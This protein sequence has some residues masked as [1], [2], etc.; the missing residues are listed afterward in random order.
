MRP[1][2]ISG[3]GV[4]ALGDEE[5]GTEEQTK[6]RSIKDNGRLT[7]LGERPTG[8]SRSESSRQKPQNDRTTETEGENGLLETPAKS[9][10]LARHMT[11]HADG[12][13]ARGKPETTSVV[14]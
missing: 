3:P 6:S 12:R 14:G 13:R 2:E 11:R 8:K 10:L 7:G 9:E 5:D 4:V 1:G